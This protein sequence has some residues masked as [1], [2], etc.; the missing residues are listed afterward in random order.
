MTPPAKVFVAG[1]S[2]YIGGAI[3]RCLVA[4]G[5]EVTG[6]VR[7]P[8]TLPDGV[9]QF[10]TGDLAVVEFELPKVDAVV[11][12]AGLGHRRGLSVNQWQL[13]NIDPSSN[14]ARAAQRAGA[15]RFVQI[16]SAYVH[17]RVHDGLVTEHTLP[18]P[19]DDY[20]ASK[21]LAER[22]VAADF[23][24]GLTIIRPAAVIGPR[25]PGNLQLAMKLLARGVP[26]PFGGL[27]NL[28]SFID[29][30]D[31]ANIVLAVLRATVPPPALL[32][33]HPDPI[34][35]PA[36]LRALAAGLGTSPRLFTLPSALLAGLARLLGRA[37]TWESL[38]GSFIADPAA[39]LALGWRPAHSLDESL[40]HA[41][42]YYH[43]TGPFA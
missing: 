17:G 7:Q 34:S 18:N 8:T 20:A 10:V 36:L 35:S 29:V 41:A 33:T 30:E 31:L 14:L 23:P 24:A 32:A 43:T 42:R 39:A 26:L 37:E 6:G 15:S 16:S 25:C 5:L 1:A 38:S 27:H 2:G 28:R 19:M 9:I 22:A 21:L 13:A 40:R 11:N 3:A 4:A 12:A